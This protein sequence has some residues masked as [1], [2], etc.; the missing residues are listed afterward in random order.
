MNQPDTVT[1]SLQ[2]YT[3]LYDFKT[4]IQL[5]GLVVETCHQTMYYIGNEAHE[6]LLD[7]IRDYEFQI[8]L[9]QSELAKL[10]KNR[11]SWFARLKY[12]I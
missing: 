4:T 12:P 8:Q 6:R 10:K 9:L 1:L 2:T 11:R 7:D 5:K 3:E